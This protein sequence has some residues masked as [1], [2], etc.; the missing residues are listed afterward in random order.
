MIIFGWG[1]R[2]VKQYGASE[3]K[4]CYHCNNQNRWAYRKDTTWFTLFFIPVIPY[5]TVYIQVCPVCG[6]YEKMDKVEFESRVEGE[7]TETSAAE[8]G[9]AA[10]N[11][12]LTET[13]RNYWKQMEELEQRKKES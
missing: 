9:K 11:D 2:T 7:I 6:Q 1:K 8:N 12:G 10:I 3:E 5:E 13:Q 4:Y